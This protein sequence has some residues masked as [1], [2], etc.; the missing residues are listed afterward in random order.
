MKIKKTYEERLRIDFCSLLRDLISSERTYF[1]IYSLH[2]LLSLSLLADFNYR[3]VKG[4][5]AGSLIGIMLDLGVYGE[6]LFVVDVN[7][8]SAKIANKISRDNVI[9]F[10]DAFSDR[11]PLQDNAK[12]YS[13]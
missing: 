8:N 5:D 4:D 9:K 7:E 2:R 6:V 12:I 10:I 11:L 1:H 13:K 3:Y